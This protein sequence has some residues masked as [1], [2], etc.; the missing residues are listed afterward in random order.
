MTHLFIRY[1]IVFR[2]L[3]NGVIPIPLEDEFIGSQ[4]LDVRSQSKWKDER[5]Y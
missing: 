1:Q 3:A 4:G 2:I 5:S